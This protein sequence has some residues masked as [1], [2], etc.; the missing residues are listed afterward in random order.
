MEYRTLGR[1]GPRVPALAFGTGTFGGVGRR[2]AGGAW[3]HRHLRRWRLTLFDTADNYSDGH[4]EKV[5]G[6]A[7]AHRPNDVLVATKTTLAISDG[8]AGGPTRHRLHSAVDASLRR[9]RR[10][11]VDLLQIHAR[12]AHTPIE[13]TLAGLDDLV[14]AGKVRHV[15]VSN[16]AGWELIKSLAAAE[17]ELKRLF[18]VARRRYL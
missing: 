11:H 15:G 14:R 5:L 12:D 2:C 8:D 16:F 17:G 6:E 4:A 3:S 13:E 1:D 18:V 10:D 7:I 9:L